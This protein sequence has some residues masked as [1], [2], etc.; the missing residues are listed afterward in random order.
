MWDACS[1]AHI[2]FRPQ[3]S[4]ELHFKFPAE[5]MAALGVEDVVDEL[6]E[7]EVLGHIVENGVIL[8]A[9]TQQL[10]G[11][12]SVEVRRGVSIDHLQ[13]AEVSEGGGA[14]GEISE[15]EW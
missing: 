12:P 8:H 13:Q 11:C 5:Q 14:Q 3:D 6:V 7:D 10:Q 9:L 4:S 1:H 2:V 15:S